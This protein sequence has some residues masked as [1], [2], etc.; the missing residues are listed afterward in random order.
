MKNVDSITKPLVSVIMPAYNVEPYIAEAIDSILKQTF[1]EFELIIADDASTDRTLSVIRSYND[2]RI[3]VVQHLKNLGYVGN[4]NALFHEAKGDVIVIQDADDYCD[5]NRLSYLYDFMITNPKVSL[6]GSSYF[7]VD[8]IG[9]KELVSLPTDIKL[10][11]QSFDQMKYPLP[12]VNGCSMLRKEIIEQGFLFR[13]L[14]YVNRAQDDDWLFRLSEN[15]VMANVSEPLYYYRSNQASMTLNPANI[16]S[17]N[18]WAADFVQ[19]LK[20]YRVERRIDLLAQ[21]L[22]HEIDSFF[23]QKKQEVLKG[24]PSF[25]ELYNAGKY[26][27]VHDRKS[28]IKWYFRA[29]LKDPFNAYIWKKIV[30]VLLHR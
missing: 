4:M 14:N 12:V 18:L 21:D 23:E 25:F 6:V 8:S 15:F 9:V 5:P 2:P 24:N 7:K 17:N 20:K 11:K 10:I 3:R 29:L 16:N 28:A 19:F 26:L 30:W 27:G 22:S 1:V 13:N